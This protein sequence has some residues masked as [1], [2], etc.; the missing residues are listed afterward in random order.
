MDELTRKRRWCGLPGRLGSG[1]AAVDDRGRGRNVLRNALRGSGSRDSLG[2]LL[3][4]RRGRDRGGELADGLIGVGVALG[5][6]VVRRQGALGL[7]VVHV[8]VVAIAT[9]GV[10]VVVLH[11][12]R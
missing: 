2:L 6:G 3:D 11:F 1:R 8:V 10:L 7:I 9:D 12:C 5:N 4:D